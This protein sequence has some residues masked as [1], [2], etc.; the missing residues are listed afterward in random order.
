MN[1][2]QLLEEI[3]EA[4][5]DGRQ[6]GESTAEYRDRKAAELKKLYTGRKEEAKTLERAYDKQAKKAKKGYKRTPNEDNVQKWAEM[7]GKATD[8]AFK[9]ADAQ[10]KE[11]KIDKI[12]SKID[13]RKQ[14]NNS[15]ALELMEAIIDF[16][17]NLFELDYEEKQN[18]H[19]NKISRVKKDENG[20]KVEVVSVADELFPYSGDAKQQFNQ[21]VLAKIND[22]IEGKGSLEDLIQFVRAGAKAKAS[23]AHEGLDEASI[24]ERDKKNRLKKEYWENK[25]NNVSMRDKM[26]AQYKIKRLADDEKLDRE[27]ADDYDRLAMREPANTPAANYWDSKYREFDQRANQEGNDK[28]ELIKNN[29][30][31]FTNRESKDLKEALELLEGA[32]KDF[33]LGSEKKDPA[34]KSAV[35]RTLRGKEATYNKH[36]GDEIKFAKRAEGAKGYRAQVNQEKAED[37]GRKAE[38]A[39]KDLRKTK[40]EYLDILRKNKGLT[41]PQA[42]AVLKRAVGESIQEMFEL[43]EGL[44]NT[45]EAKNIFG[46]ETDRG[47]LEDDISTTVTGKTLNQ[48]IEDGVKKVTEPKKEA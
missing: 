23:R 29:R 21:K 8:T 9:G 43:I 24:C 36:V 3:M 18:I 46:K 30:K 5:A 19:P 48:H 6:E 20:E 47:S 42:H 34:T 7:Q 4:L 17:D 37:A 39:N 22:M 35:G 45:N 32:I 26:N 10:T 25:L 14:M 44:Y 12:K 33:F 28:Q 40:G 2:Y 38:A 13:W 16:A 31:K 11:F 1:I 27:I 41:N 15:E